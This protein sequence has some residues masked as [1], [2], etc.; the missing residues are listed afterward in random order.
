MKDYQ[1]MIRDDK[2]KKARSIANGLQDWKQSRQLEQKQDFA[3]LT[4]TASPMQ[5]AL[6]TRLKVAKHLVSEKAL[7][8]LEEV[9]LAW[10]E[11]GIP[12]SVLRRHLDN[13]DSTQS[14]NNAESTGAAVV[15]D[16]RVVLAKLL[17]FLLVKG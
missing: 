5:A 17:A 8:E 15:D 6:L 11:A 3:T 4:T 13:N 14:G 12:V 7:N 10:V 1:A 9:T 16:D 2:I